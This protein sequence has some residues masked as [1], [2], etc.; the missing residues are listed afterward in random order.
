MCCLRNP[1]LFVL[2]CY[3]SRVVYYIFSP[4]TFVVV[5]GMNTGSAA[6]QIADKGIANVGAYDSQAPSQDNQ[7]PQLEK[8]AMSDQVPVVHP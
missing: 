2:L 1:H 4:K 5:I 3:I 8:L 7:V 6:T